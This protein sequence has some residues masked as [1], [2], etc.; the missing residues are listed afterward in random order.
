MAHIWGQERLTTSR[1]KKGPRNTER[2]SLPEQ[3]SGVPSAGIPSPGPPLWQSTW[4]SQR[5]SAPHH[6]PRG[7]VLGDAAPYCTYSSEHGAWH[8]ARAPETIKTVMI[9][10]VTKKT[11]PKYPP[12]G[13][14]AGVTRQAQVKIWLLESK[15]TCMPEDKILPRLQNLRYEWLHH[16]PET[17]CI[18]TRKAEEMVQG[19]S[20]HYAL[21]PSPITWCR[22]LT[23]PSS[24][25]TGNSPGLS[26]Q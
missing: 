13:A 23:H 1:A 17:F 21:P 8:R 18:V 11:C 10:I 12:A 7:Y 20:P 19:L 6:L 9:M 22:S 14:C 25:D 5:A 26:H 4:T 15:T 24:Q 3:R 16:K 2:T